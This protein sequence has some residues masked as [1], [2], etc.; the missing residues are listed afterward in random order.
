MSRR[1]A[2]LAWDEAV[3]VKKASYATGTLGWVLG[4]YRQ[5]PGYKALRPA[6]RTNYEACFDRLH[7]YRKQPI[8]GL[9]HRHIM[10][11]RDDLAATPGMAN[12]MIAALQAVCAFA[13]RRGYIEINP[14]TEIERFKLKGWRRWSD[15][16]L[17]AFHAGA[18]EPLKRAL[19]LALY[20]GQRCADLVAMRWSDV[21]DTGIR[22]TQAKTGTPL[23]VPIHPV[24]REHLKAWR[25][26]AATTVLTNQHGRPWKNGHA[27]TGR[28]SQTIEELHLKGCTLHGLRKTAAAL[29]AEAGC[30]TRMIMAVTGHASLGEVERYTREVDQRAL[31]QAAVK[32]L[33]HGM[34]GKTPCKSLKAKASNVP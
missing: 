1:D 33:R 11:V 25:P 9:K 6:T 12:R 18:P 32:K 23:V 17:A 24:L 22:V 5:S 29:L 15:A 7:K 16:E 3:G 34:F 30:T 21:S 28:F 26:A 31:A 19:I 8:A 2:E 27:L 13:R 10:K 4:E 14:A 20:T